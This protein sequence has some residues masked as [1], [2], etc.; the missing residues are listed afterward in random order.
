MLALAACGKPFNVKPRTDLPAAIYSVSGRSADVEIQARL[1]TDEDFLDSTFDANLIQ[2]GLLPVR[3]SVK[4]LASGPLDLRHSKYQ[5]EIG[6]VVYKEVDPN[7][8]FKR[9][10]SYYQFTTYNVYGYK[11]SREDF[12]SYRL[13]VDAAIGPGGITEGFLFFDVPPAVSEERGVTLISS[14]LSAHAR[15][16]SGRLELKLN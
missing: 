9:L 11:Q 6:N 15:G 2:A 3:L 4:N 16:G 14:N 8:A 7:R 10:I 13:N 5:V 12:I 1:V